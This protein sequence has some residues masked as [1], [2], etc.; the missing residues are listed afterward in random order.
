M[1]YRFL[2]LLVTIGSIHNTYATSPQELFAQGNTHYKNE[3]YEQAFQAYQAIPHK[4]SIIHYNLGNCAYH[5]NQLG[6]AL[7]HWRRAETDWG[8]FNRAELIHNIKLVKAKLRELQGNQPKQTSFIVSAAQHCKK[9]TVSLVKSIKLLYLQLVFLCLWLSI[10]LLKR[11]SG[12]RR[13]R[14][15]TAPLLICL[16]G[17]GSMLA[18]KYGLRLSPHGIVTASKGTL[19]SGPGETYQAIITVKE[20]T[21]G[22]INKQAENYYKITING[23]LGWISNTVFEKI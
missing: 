16:C 11:W 14:W 20:G 9:V 2:L 3:Q 19:R 4:H 18:I 17:A 15:I 8:I 12:A 6:K 23:K 22:I 13:F 7:L 10:F 21:E 1:L 5:M